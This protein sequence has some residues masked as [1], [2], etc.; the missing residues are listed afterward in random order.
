VYVISKGRAE[1]GLTARMLIRDEVPFNLVVEPQEHTAYA[2]RYES[3][4]TTILQTPFSNLGK[5]G[6]PARNFCWEH[7]L[8]QGHR[9]HWILD[10]NIGYTCRWYAGYR[11]R[12][13]SGPAFAVVEDFTE[14][15]DNVG[16]SGM[17]Y[18][19]FI[20]PGIAP[21]FTNVHVYSCLLID[22]QLSVRWRLRYNEDTDLCLQ[23]LT[24]GLTTILVNVFSIEKAA[25]MTMKGGNTDELYAGDGRLRMA[26]SLER[27]WPGIVRVDERSG[28]PQHVVNWKQHFKTPLSL[29]SDVDPT[30][31]PRFDEYGYR[32]EAVQQSVRSARLRRLLVAYNE[33]HGK[34]A[35]A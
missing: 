9:R 4:Y 35:P 22:N 23:V 19:Q 15:Y 13:A 12:C 34:E 5:G 33:K 25:T 21:Y 8:E 20:R 7:A 2:A 24:S 11:I 29:R 26:R 30:A 17:N 14:R 1:N 16:I 32:L 10:D 3:D 6:T 31:L 27:V 18:R 28:R